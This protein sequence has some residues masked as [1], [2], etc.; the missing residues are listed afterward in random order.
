MLDTTLGRHQVQERSSVCLEVTVQEC[1]PDGFWGSVSSG[2][3]DTKTIPLITWQTWFERWAETLKD[4]L[5][6]AAAYEVTLRLTGDGE[7]Q[8]LN[9]QYRHCHQP[10]DVLAFAALE[11]DSPRPELGELPLSLGDIVVSVET[12]QRQAQGEGHPLATELT[13]LAAHGFLHLLGW[14]HPDAVA[15]KR[16]IEKQV[17][18]LGQTGLPKRERTSLDLFAFLGP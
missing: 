4:D 8:A 17:L 9:A 3:P 15:L 13:W 12:A 1:Y 6:P 11:W 16:M 2:D 18:L 7:I 10:T 14:D 5:P